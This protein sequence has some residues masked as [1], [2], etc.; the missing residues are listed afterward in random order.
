M[1]LAQFAG[2]EEHLVMQGNH[3]I[4]AVSLNNP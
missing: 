1:T 3:R 2:E 4:D